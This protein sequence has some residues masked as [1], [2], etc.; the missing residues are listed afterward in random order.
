[1]TSITLSEASV[2]GENWRQRRVS[3]PLGLTLFA[4]EEEKP[5]TVTI[6]YGNGMVDKFDMK[7]SPD[8]QI[9]P[10]QYDISVSY[11]PQAGTNSKLEAVGGSSGLI[12]NDDKL[13]DLDSIKVFNPT[14]YKLTRDDGTIYI[15]NDKT[16][17]ESITDVNGNVLT[18]EEDGVIHSDGKS[19][20]FERDS[21][22]GLQELLDLL[23]KR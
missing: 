13:Y 6:D 7:L 16:G 11:I 23:A 14:K 21:Q 12:F 8:Q 19:I 17:V 15:I 3:G 20:V 5:H 22:E 4:W 2:P 10:M 18:F 1:M 9:L